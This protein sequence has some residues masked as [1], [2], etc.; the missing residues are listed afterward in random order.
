M[1]VFVEYSELWTGLIM[2]SIDN[3]EYI[4]KIDLV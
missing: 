3:A 1:Y 4:M 2:I